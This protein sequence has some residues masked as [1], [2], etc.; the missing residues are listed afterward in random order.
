VSVTGWRANVCPHACPVGRQWAGREAK[1]SDMTRDNV[2]VV[3]NTPRTL[4]FVPAAR[5]YEREVLAY[6]YGEAPY[7]VARVTNA[8]VGN[9]PYP[10]TGFIVSVDTEYLTATLDRWASGMFYARVIATEA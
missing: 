2:H 4:V 10:T 3:T 8:L 5:E 7:V 6:P 1:G 9:N